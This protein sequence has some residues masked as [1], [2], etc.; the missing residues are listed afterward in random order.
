MVEIDIKMMY[1]SSPI[2]VRKEY[3]VNQ[4]QF[5]LLHDMEETCII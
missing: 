1:D 4:T 2:I 5:T 3:F